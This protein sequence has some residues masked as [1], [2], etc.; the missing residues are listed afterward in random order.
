MIV[1]KT[2]ENISSG[3]SVPYPSKMEDREAMKEQAMAYL[4]LLGLGTRLDS[5]MGKW[6]RSEEAAA[7][8]FGDDLSVA[9][10]WK[11]LGIEEGDCMDKGYNF[12]SAIF[13][14]LKS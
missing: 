3:G 13:I 10:M 4:F 2:L 8:V 14:S 1:R 9:A 12:K 6:I 11:D 7:A 5:G